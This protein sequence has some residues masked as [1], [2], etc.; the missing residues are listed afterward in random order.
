MIEA[1]YAII[2][3]VFASLGVLAL[4]NHLVRGSELR[5]AIAEHREAGKQLDD[6][7]VT[8][9]A[10]LEELKFETD[11]MD[12][13]RVALDKQARCMLD[14]EENYKMAQAAALESERKSRKEIR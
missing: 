7:I 2:I 5:E 9:K 8:V 14:L 3:V 11:A 13:E 6:R 12:D 4:F 1:V 10:E